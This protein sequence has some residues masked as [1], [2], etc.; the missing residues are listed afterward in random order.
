MS[1]ETWKGKPYTFLKQRRNDFGN[2]RLSLTWN[3]QEQIKQSVSKTQ[4]HIKYW[5]TT[6]IVSEELT[7]PDE[8]SIFLW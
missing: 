6:N 7:M 3:M 1:L 8:L 4:N 5:K 2:Y